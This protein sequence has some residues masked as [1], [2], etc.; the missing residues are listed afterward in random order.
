L[1]CT[2][3]QNPF[4]L[5]KHMPAL[6]CGSLAY[7]SIAV[8]GGK[9]SD[10]IL[11]DRIHSLNVSFFV[12]QMR[13]EYGGCAA[14]I[15]YAYKLLGGEPVIVGAIGEDGAD[16]LERLHKLGIATDHISTVLGTLTAQAYIMTDE[17]N[18]Q[19]TSFHPGA[20]MHAHDVAIPEKKARIAILAPDGKEATL[21]HARQCKAHGIDMIFDPG[22]GLPMFS[23]TELAP[24]IADAAYV[25]VNDYEASMVSEKLGKTERE[26][27]VGKK[28]VIITRGEHGCEVFDG[29]AW[30]S[31]AGAKAESVVDPTG[32]GDA[33]RGALLW[34]LEN[35]RSWL[36]AAR[37]GNVVG[38][39]KVAHQGGQNYTMTAAQ[40]LALLG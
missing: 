17:A 19:I 18:N 34:A 1:R 4:T 29:A 25:V 2:P 7:D 8:F 40:V 21:T 32:C 26:W 23:G 39:I 14:N 35:G 36:D 13:R 24:L 10:H 31:V 3:Q 30:A 22:Q 33:F 16:Y 9:F 37:V 6:I 11:A 5:E 27:C 28:G 20:M 12:P 38:A 15:A